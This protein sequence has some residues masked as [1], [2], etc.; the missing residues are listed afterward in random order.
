MNSTASAELA[1]DFIVY[2]NMTGLNVDCFHAQILRAIANNGVFGED[3]SDCLKIEF[4]EIF[5]TVKKV[6]V[7]RAFLF[8]V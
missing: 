1:T 2:A 3:L 6:N 4:R 7:R 8:C 5:C